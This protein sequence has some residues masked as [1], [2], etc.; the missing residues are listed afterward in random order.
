MADKFIKSSCSL[1]AKI[2]RERSSEFESQREQLFV[3]PL[4]S[5]FISNIF[6]NNN[7]TL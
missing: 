4:F 6:L 2:P 7:F 1:M 5:F 3:K